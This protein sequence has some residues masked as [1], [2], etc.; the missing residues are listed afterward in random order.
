MNSLNAQRTAVILDMTYNLGSIRADKWPKFNAALRS[1]KWEEA[2]KE[3][4]DSKYAKQVKSRAV[5]NA[6]IMR[7]G[8][9]HKK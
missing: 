7:D 6:A 4:M 8:Q 2:A 1:C 9:M 3:I 5:R